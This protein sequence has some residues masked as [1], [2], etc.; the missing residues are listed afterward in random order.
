[1]EA[2]LA[3]FGRIDAVIN[4]AGHGRPQPFHRFRSAAV[5]GANPRSHCRPAPTRPAHGDRGPQGRHMIC[6]HHWVLCPGRSPV[7]HNQRKDECVL[8]S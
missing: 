7:V 2:A 5:T 8:P 4:N 1:M 3:R 6:I